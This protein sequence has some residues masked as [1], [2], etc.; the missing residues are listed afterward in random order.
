MSRLVLGCGLLVLSLFA[1]GCGGGEVASIPAVSPVVA[2][3]AGE[4]DQLMDEMGGGAS[5]KAGAPAGG[6]AEPKPAAEK[7]PAE[8]PAT[9][10][11]KPEAKPAPTPAKP[12]AKPAP[13]PA[14]K[15]P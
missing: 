3:A 2:P 7:P 13:A 6:E 4:D 12:E 8:A 14:P 11:A 10:P 9:A 1:A 5:E 15:K